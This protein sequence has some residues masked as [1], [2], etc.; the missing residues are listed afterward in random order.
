MNGNVAE[1]FA[2]ACQGEAP[3]SGYGWVGNFWTIHESYLYGSEE[4]R[5]APF[6]S[7]GPSEALE[8]DERPHKA[9]ILLLLLFLRTV[10]YLHYDN[11]INVS[12][13]CSQRSFVRNVSGLKIML[14][15]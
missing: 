3:Q 10:Q 13:R 5:G 12:V 14:C 9:L 6:T 11:A 4:S 1:N 8:H 7:P 15:F 2:R